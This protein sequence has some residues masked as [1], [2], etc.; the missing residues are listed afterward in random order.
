M[1]KKTIKGT[2][3][4]ELPILFRALLVYI[5]LKVVFDTMV[6]LSYLILYLV[7]WSGK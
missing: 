1:S 3:W 7:K 2:K 4:M 5:T 6:I